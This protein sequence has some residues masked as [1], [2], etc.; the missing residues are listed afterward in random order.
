LEALSNSYSYETLANE[1]EACPKTIKKKLEEF[2][3]KE[4]A[5]KALKENQKNKQKRRVVVRF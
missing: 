4:F 1:L 3:L 5:D 2:N